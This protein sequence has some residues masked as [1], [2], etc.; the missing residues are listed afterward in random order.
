[1][2]ISRIITSPLNPITVWLLKIYIL[3]VNIQNVVGFALERVLRNSILLL[4]LAVAVSVILSREFSI[5][6]VD[7]FIDYTA[8]GTQYGCRLVL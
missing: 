8:N 4:N 1:M 3:G 5:T 2:V 6:V 7:Y